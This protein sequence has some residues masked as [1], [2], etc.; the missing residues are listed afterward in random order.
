MLCSLGVRLQDIITFCDRGAAGGVL[1]TGVR[2]C[3]SKSLCFH[4][5]LSRSVTTELNTLMFG[6]GSNTVDMNKKNNKKMNFKKRNPLKWSEIHCCLNFKFPPCSHG[7]LDIRKDDAEAAVNR[8]YNFSS[9]RRALMAILSSISCCWKQSLLGKSSSMHSS[10]TLLLLVTD[11]PC[12]LSVPPPPPHQ[13]LSIHLFHQQP[14]SGSKNF[15]HL[16]TSVCSRGFCHWMCS[17]IQPTLNQ[18]E[19]SA[20]CSWLNARIQQLVYVPCTRKCILIGCF[21]WSTA[22]PELKRGTKREADKSHLWRRYCS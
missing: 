2:H 22:L 14:P 17:S 9:H 5:H 4:S 19:H 11:K 8:F 7:L 15:S 3:W 16:T 18:N 12:L 21:K 20:T 13:S 1:G 6:Q 10:C